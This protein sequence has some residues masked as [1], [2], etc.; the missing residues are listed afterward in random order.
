MFPFLL[1]RIIFG[2]QCYPDNFIRYW[3]EKKKVAVRN[4]QSDAV[5]PISSILSKLFY[6]S[7]FIYTS[8]FAALCRVQL[9]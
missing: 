3:Q 6:T 7:V 1:L 4:L 2:L 8:I 9:L 5:V